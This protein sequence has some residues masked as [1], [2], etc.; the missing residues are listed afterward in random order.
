VLA[1]AFLLA[2]SVGC[3]GDG[4]G[5]QSAQST[6]PAQ[7]PPSDNAFP[8]N[9]TTTGPDVITTPGTTAKKEPGQAGGG[10]TATCIGSC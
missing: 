3:G 4:S 9:G 8:T 10:S 7:A 2:T 5:D 6:Q 1:T